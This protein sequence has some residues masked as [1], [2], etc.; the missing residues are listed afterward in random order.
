MAV[1][2]RDT[3]VAG[4]EHIVHFY[5][6]EPE[7]VAAVGP[8]LAAAARAGETAI[9]IAT[10]AHRHAFE[11]AL[12]AD[13]IDL[14]RARADES[15]LSLDAAS[16][17]AAFIVDG[18]IDHDAFHELIGGLVRKA[19][20]SGRAVRAYGE[21]VALLWDA[22]NVI[23]AIELETLWN[24]LG[25]ELPFSLFCSYPAASVAGSEHAAALHHVCHLHSSVL[26][27]S[28]D[29]EQPRDGKEPPEHV[30]PHALD[31]TAELGVSISLPAK[32]D[33]P[34]RARRIVVA[35]LRRW[36]HSD[37]LVNDAALMVTELTSNAVRHACSAFSLA[38]RVETSTLRVEVRDHTPLH[39][40]LP[41]GGLIPESLHGLGIVEAIA[42]RW[43]VESTYD[44]KLVWAELPC[45]LT[46]GYGVPGRA[47]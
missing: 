36:E 30:Q 25:R 37:T 21:M 15:F 18:Q 35:A 46:S 12:E 5:A 17:M 47:R 7:L 33:S 34:G 45:R 43:G 27:P 3:V 44:G 22:G 4:G 41:N 29:A 24:D 32:P 19:A 39:I 1:E 23:A 11:A 10:A 8:Y 6:R 13:G 28:A 40:A 9:V 2:T 26:G 31:T 20:E 42:T 38:V 16:T 14:G